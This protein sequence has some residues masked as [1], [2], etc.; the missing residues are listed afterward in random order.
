[1]HTGKIAGLLLA[2]ILIL[3]TIPT[4]YASAA[5]QEQTKA[6]KFIEIAE[7][8][9]EHADKLIDK[10]KE[11][12]VDVTAANNLMGEGTKL[13]NEAK[14]A[15]SKN[16]FQ[17]AFTKARQAQEKFRDALISL[18]TPAHEAAQEQGRG[19]LVAVDNAYERI[20][21]LRDAIAKIPVTPENE[22]PLNWAKM[23]LTQAENSLT[24]A[25]NA[26]Q[27][28]EFNVD[29]AARKLA[30]ATKYISQAFA[31]LKHIGNR[32]FFWHAENYL[33]AIEKH[34]EKVKDKVNQL[35]EKGYN[36]QELQTKLTK[37]DELIQKARASALAGDK[38]ATLAFIKEIDR[39]L[40]E[41]TKETVKLH[42]GK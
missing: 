13:L 5:Q 40:Q 21:R 6:E 8:A 32:A 41:I 36:V 37:V 29:L 34:V 15:F 30:E 31:A 1:M 2:S 22:K 20:Q 12:G 19:I 35:A 39:L 28:Y 10:A 17:T 26:I 3:A 38:K 11:G 25:R 14:D 9:K 7:Q 16:N 27:K 24:D 18:K 42:K 23:N 33:N 4:L